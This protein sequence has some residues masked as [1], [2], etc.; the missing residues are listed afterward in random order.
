MLTCIVSAVSGQKPMTEGT[1]VYKVKLT[2]V[3]D[4]TFKGTYTF[5]FKD[6]EMKKELKL[7]SGYDD[8][9][10]FDFDAGKIYNLQ[11]RNGVK[12]A[13]Q[14]SMDELIRKQQNYSGF[15]LTNER[16]THDVA[17]TTTYTGTVTYKNG[18]TSE[19]YYTREWKPA[20][21]TTYNR[22]PGANFIPLRFYYSEENG[23][24]MSFEAERLD[25]TPI[26]SSVFRIPPDYKMISYDEYKQISKE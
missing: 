7:E 16:K 4:K 19:I 18:A 23:I 20:H 5:S 21:A 12:Y 24:K 8:V 1:L 13:I 25:A 9:T 26:A 17:N 3:D 6:K 15:Q 22:F 14:L 10:L 11:S 2:S